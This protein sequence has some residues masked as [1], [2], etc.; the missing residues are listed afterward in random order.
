M[1]VGATE[2]SFFDAWHPDSEHLFNVSSQLKRVCWELWDPTFRL[3]G[4]D[5]DINLMSCFQPQLAQFQKKAL[6]TVVKSM[7]LED[8]PDAKFWIEEKLDGERMQLHYHNGAFRFWSRKAKDYTYLYG[9]DF[10]SGSLTQFLKKAFNPKVKSII[11]D[12]EMITWDPKLDTIVGFGT[13]KTAAIEQANNPANEECNRPLCE[14]DL[15]YFLG[16]F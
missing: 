10:N 16:N 14:W 13:L 2:K 7:H 11:L 1:K 6:E 8:E 15:P 3:G 12:G 5:L 4:E 9:E